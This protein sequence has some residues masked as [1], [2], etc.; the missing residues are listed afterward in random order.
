MRENGSFDGESDEQAGFHK[1]YGKKSLRISKI[2][3]QYETDS[4]RK[5][6]EIFRCIE[7]VAM[8][9][10]PD[11]MRRKKRHNVKEILRYV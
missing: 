7:R 9:E 2:V 3:I 6:K 1:R 5:C 11:D 8:E 10:S 4:V